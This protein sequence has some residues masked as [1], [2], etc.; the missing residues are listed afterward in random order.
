VAAADRTVAA[1]ADRRQ[2]DRAADPGG[3]HRGDHAAVDHLV[4]L[5]RGHHEHVGGA[6]EQPR[7]HRGIGLVTG[8]ELDRH[9]PGRG[10]AAAEHA[11]HVAGRG[12]VI[13]ERAPDISGGS[14]DS[15]GG[16]HTAA[17][18]GGAAAAV[19]EESGLD[20]GPGC[21]NACGMVQLIAPVTAAIRELR[22]VRFGD[23]ERRQVAR[24]PDGSV[25]LL[26]RAREAGGGDLTVLG[27][28]TQARYKISGALRF[29]A[30][31]VLSPVA[32]R[33]VLGLPLD[34]LTDRVV[35]LDE[36]WGRP[37]RDLRD[38]MAE[39]APEAAATALAIAVREHAV[40]RTSPRCI[41]GA[42][43]MIMIEGEP[44]DAA[45]IIVSGTC[46]VFKTVNGDDIDLRELGPGEVF[47]ETAILSGAR[48][49]ASVQALETLVLQVV[50]PEA[51]EEG[52][53]LHTGLGRFVRTLAERFR[54]VDERLAKLDPE[55]RVSSRP[56]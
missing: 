44:G 15:D 56:R 48:R 43:D 55:P 4:A 8:H 49:S 17:T 53:G 7:E 39:L 30:R 29:T 26:F 5:D 19:L 14:H 1:G 40:Q 35:P 45:Y 34:A 46:R 16:D 3:G 47:G 23:G 33:A 36:L 21:R 10:G 38:R 28:L 11:R 32:A 27:P 20:S 41:Y 13:D 12:E 9:A 52:V 18:L 37:G 51:L 31:A 42:G 2:L 50:S 25:S 22:V 54:E 24:I 6:G